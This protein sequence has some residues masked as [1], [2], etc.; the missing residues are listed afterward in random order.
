MS[1]A[2]WTNSTRNF[3][4][5]DDY[6]LLEV[7]LSENRNSLNRREANS[8]RRVAERV[9]ARWR[10]ETDLKAALERRNPMNQSH[11]VAL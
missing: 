5:S 7:S 11:S 9:M 3:Q 8:A 6:L 10:K 4:T 2:R 1:F